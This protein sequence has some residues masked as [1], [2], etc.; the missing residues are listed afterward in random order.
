MFTSKDKT[1]ET[2]KGQTS[3]AELFQR[4]I[5]TTTRNDERAEIKI[6][7]IAHGT[8]REASTSQTERAGRERERET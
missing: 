6:Y 3:K 7:Q 8:H 2:F 4:A 5:T 1:P